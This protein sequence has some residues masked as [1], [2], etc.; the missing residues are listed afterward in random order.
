[1]RANGEE[2]V[3]PIAY[4]P[5]EL[6]AS[7]KE[8]EVLSEF[9]RMTSNNS[10]A[11]RRRTCGQPKSLATLICFFCRNGPHFLHLFLGLNIH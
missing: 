10:S 6:S 4:D 1:M 2:C 8:A 3:G 11:L 7:H 9:S 5:D